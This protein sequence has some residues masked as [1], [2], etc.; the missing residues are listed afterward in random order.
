M[1][2]NDSISEKNHKSKRDIV[3][4]WYVKQKEEHNQKI[5]Q[6][7]EKKKKATKSDRRL[8]EYLRSQEW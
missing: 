1:T 5:K 6:E 2:E 8:Q 4:D 7:K 3:L